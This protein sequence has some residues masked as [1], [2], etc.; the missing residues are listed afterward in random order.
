MPLG[1]W[2]SFLILLGKKTRP[3]A[4]VADAEVK[5]FAEAHGGTMTAVG[6]TNAVAQDL[7]LTA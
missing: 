4:L 5:E 1:Y 3:V 6:A 7:Y 2:N